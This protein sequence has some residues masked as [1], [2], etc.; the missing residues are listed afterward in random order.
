MVISLGAI[1][2]NSD[3]LTFE[4]VDLPAGGTLR[5]FSANGLGDPIT[6]PGTRVID[7]LGRVVFQ[8]ADEA[9]A[10]PYATIGFRVSDREL[11]QSI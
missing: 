8:P 6:A 4:I 10:A 11:L 5:Q 2:F 7:A 9:T 3:P 1:D